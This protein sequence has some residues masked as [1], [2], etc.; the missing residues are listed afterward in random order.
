MGV[1]GI[2]EGDEL[3]K[4]V[5]VNPKRLKTLNFFQLP[6]EK[7][8]M[9][10]MPHRNVSWSS[11]ERILGLMEAERDTVSPSVVSDYAAR[12][13]LPT[14]LLCPWNSPGRNTGVGCHVLLQEEDIPDPGIK[15]RSPALALADSL[16]SEPYI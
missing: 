6:L 15:P 8:E 2:E 13:S 11:I 9:T 4:Q 10:H 3:V 12:G 14:R 5:E 7:M 1:F 16:P